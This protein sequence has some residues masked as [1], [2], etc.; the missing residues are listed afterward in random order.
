MKHLLSLL[1]RAGDLAIVCH[2]I[3]TNEK[4]ELVSSMWVCSSSVHAWANSRSQ[5]SD[6]MKTFLDDPLSKEV[7]KAVQTWYGRVKGM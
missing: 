3:G 6:E 2:M 4:S 1:G 5:T 7:I